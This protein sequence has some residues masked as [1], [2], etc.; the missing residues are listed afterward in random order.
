MGE[1]EEDTVVVVV[2]ETE[3]VDVSPGRGASTAA[4]A[5]GSG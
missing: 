1:E 4:I 2:E 5:I 3:G